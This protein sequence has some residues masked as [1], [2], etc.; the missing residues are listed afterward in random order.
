[1]LKFSSGAIIIYFIC[2]CF[3]I[4]GQTTSFNDVFN[5]YFEQNFENNTIGTYS[6]SEWNEDWNY[7][8]WSNRQVPPEILY[9][10]VIEN[11]T[12]VMRWH[13]PEGSVGPEQGGGQ[14]LAPL[15]SVFDELYFSYRLKFKPGFEWVLGGKIPGLRGGPEWSGFDPPGWSDGFVVLLMWNSTPQ[16]TFYY[17]HHDQDHMYGDS[18]EWDY[19]L[20]PG[21]WYTITVRIVMNTIGE[22]G[23]NNDGILEGYINDKLY[24]QL[25]NLRFRNIDS[26]GTDQLYVA[27][28]FGGDGEQWAAKKDEWLDVDDFIVFSYKDDVIVPR[29]NTPSS[30]DRI[31]LHP[32]IF[33][34][35]SLWR[36]S[37]SATPLSSKT[38]E[39]KW[40]HY[41]IP[42]SYSIQRKKSTD[43]VFTTIASL[44]YKNVIYTDKEL[45]PLTQ[46]EYRILTNDI[47]SDTIAVS[48]FS[49]GTPNPPSNL[50]ASAVLKRQINVSWTDNSVNELGFKVERSASPD[51][52]VNIASLN[53]NTR[54]YS[55]INLTPNTTYYYRVYAHNEDGNSGYS[56]VLEVK[57]LPLEPPA[58][59]TG[60]S[61]SDITKNSL[62]LTWIDNSNNEK[63]FAIMS[64]ATSGSG[65]T[66]LA[67]VGPGITSYNCMGLS[68]DHEYYYLIRA[69]NDDGNSGYS[70]ELYVKT[71]PLNPPAAPG[72]LYTS[73]I[74]KHS[75]NL[76]WTDNSENE[77]GFSIEQSGQ[78]DT[79]FVKI[80]TVD[81]NIT[82]CLVTGLTLNTTYLYRIS[83]FN[84]DGN[85]GYSNIIEAKTFGLQP[86]EAPSSLDVFAITKNT[87]SLFWTDN[88]NNEE[89]FYIDR[90]KSLAD[91]FTRIAAVTSNVTTYTDSYLTPDCIY[92]YRIRA[93][94]EDG[95][96]D[97]SDILEVKTSSLN[98][99][100]APS[101]LKADT[102][103][104]NWLT[105]VWSDNSTNE[106]GFRIE[107]T[108]D[109]NSVFIVLADIDNPDITEYTDMGLTDNTTYYY[110]VQ[111]YNDDGLSGYLGILKVVT[112]E[113]KPPQPPS[114]LSPSQVT[115]NTI[116]L[117]WMDNSSDETG[118]AIKRAS[119]P[120]KSFVT[121][122]MTS[123][124]ATSFVDENLNPST[125]YHYL[126]NAINKAGNSN[127]SNTAIAS[128]LSVSEFNRI[129]DGLVAYYN[130]N[131]SSDNIVYDYSKYDKPLNL[132]I[133]DTLGIL[134]NANNKL[135]LLSNNY[136]KSINPATKIVNACKN[137]SE[138]T[139]ECWIKASST[140]LPDPENILTI[141]NNKNE[142]CATLA[143][144]HVSIND[145][146]SY[147]YLIR[148]AT[149]S[150]ASN[151]AP[152]LYTR[153][154]LTYLSLHHIV[155]VR[156]ENGIE[157]LFINGKEAANSIRPYDFENWD[158]NSYL[159]LGNDA[160]LDS[161]W[162]GT[163]YI[164]AIYNLALS[165]D[166]IITN[167]NAGPKDNLPKSDINY[168]IEISPNPSEGMIN[169]RIIPLSEDEYADKTMIQICDIMGNLKYSEIIADPNRELRKTID[170][171]EFVKGIYLLRVIANDHFNSKKFIIK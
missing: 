131:Y 73:D 54:N 18:E 112:P 88:A 36:K 89:G 75:I 79:V 158:N 19:T 127:N 121:I 68:P 22:N 110:R 83:A 119:A 155:Y 39:L 21:I 157:K 57:T 123:A 166:Q 91:N 92:F 114:L 111:A 14:W 49:P 156:Y 56:S 7:P 170:L 61:A 115:L 69:F 108:T 160:D 118:F 58:A 146:K 136:I 109:T 11:G 53:Y 40:D 84:D 16:P 132:S 86:P 129:W 28:F 142:I 41:P 120:Y 165:Q 153:D 138:I 171:S 51:N 25:S 26:I 143:Q 102:I 70:N 82:S 152:N 38:I 67:T 45:Q 43:T 71:L 46:Y 9:D 137:T 17:Y 5:V 31:L 10:S 52:F 159:I 169:L 76:A 95:T 77:S 168:E 29:G 64:S 44:P 85:S 145:D 148:L 139:I 141:S 162:N 42:H 62:H 50:S 78:A 135:E 23:G 30:S 4:S 107:R 34:K 59:P 125:T 144:E 90:S 122:K 167:Y 87:L 93:F 63:G 151:G 65:F 113:L 150:T 33:I 24:C 81:Q 163:F 20:T 27:S 8:E 130:F 100:D 2:T 103:N 80:D 105:L 55:D 149:K 94:N 101:S 134:W 126:V 32:Y 35:D 97:F 124:D 72:Q 161:P 1:M 117:N 116:T 60:L 15:N 96:S 154:E 98:S 66:Q 140:S 104:Y 99:P 106:S 48:T 164:V 13:Y 37:L 3:S 6:N 12:K 74:T 47:F 133:G 128:T 147:K